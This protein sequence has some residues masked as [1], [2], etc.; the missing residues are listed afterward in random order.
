[1]TR[2]ERIKELF[3]CGA[4]QSPYDVTVW[5]PIGVY[6]NVAGEDEPA[7][8]PPEGRRPCQAGEVQLIFVGAIVDPERYAT[9]LGMRVER[10]G[11]LPPGPN[12]KGEALERY[13]EV[14]IVEAVLLP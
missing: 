3:M 4:Q 11:G 8:S 9:A 7:M 10:I 6:F 2:N 5:T 13:R 12:V 14:Q 1:M